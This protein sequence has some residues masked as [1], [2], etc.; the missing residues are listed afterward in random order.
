MNAMRITGVILLLL[1]LA[2]LLTGGFSFTREKTAAKVG[3]VELKVNERESFNIPQWLSV[4]AM[5]IGGLVLVAGFR[6]S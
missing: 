2:G 5:V 3:P 1:G 6:K 4:G